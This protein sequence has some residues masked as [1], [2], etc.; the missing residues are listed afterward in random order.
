[1]SFFKMAGNIAS[2]FSQNLEV[3]PHPNLNKLFLQ[4]GV[5]P[6]GERYVFYIRNQ[7]HKYLP[8]TPG[9]LSQR[10][11][12]LEDSIF[13]SGAQSPFSDHINFAPQEFFQIDYQSGR[14]PG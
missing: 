3:I 4:K 5:L 10:S 8:T 13:N 1:M 2:R 11:G 6:T 9:H 12:L 14:K 7:L